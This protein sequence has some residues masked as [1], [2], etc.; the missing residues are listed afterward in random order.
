MASSAPLVVLSKPSFPYR[1]SFGVHALLFGIAATGILGTS[2]SARAQEDSDRPEAAKPVVVPPLVEHHHEAIYPPEELSARKH[3]EVVLVVTV[4]SEGHVTNVEVGQ[5]G[6]KPFDDAAIVAMRLWTFRPATRD[7]KPVASRFRVPFH[8]APPEIASPE[9]VPAPGIHGQVQIANEPAASAASTSNEPA[10]PK[11]PDE[12]PKEVRVIGRSS[13]PS[14]GGGDHDIAIGKLSAV[15]HM[16]AASLLRLAPGVLLTNE[17]GTG[18]PNQIFLR[19][20]DAREGQDIEFSVDGIP[21]NEV[22]NPHGNGTADTHFIIP[23]LV[24]RLRVVEGPFAPQQG[25]YAVAGSALYDVGLAEPGLSMKATMGSFATKRLLVMWRPEGAHEHTFGGAELFSSDGFGQNRASERATAMG[26]Y[27]GHLGE[28]GSYRILA[29]S[30]ATHYAQ[31]GVLRLDDV[32]AGRKDFY[33][34]YDTSQGGDSSRHSIGVTL[35]GKIGETKLS[36]SAFLIFRDFRLRQ[37]FT[38]FLNDPQQTW[39]SVHVQRGDLIDQRSQ[40]TTFGGRGSARESGNLFGQKQEFELGYLA[41][42]DRTDATQQRDRAGTTIPYLTDLALTSG[43]VNVGLYADASIKPLRW[44]TLRGGLRGDLY[45]YLVTNHCAQTSQSSFGGDPL[46][47]ECFSSDRLGY[48]SP[49]QTASTSASL[50][51]PRGT[52]LVGPFDGFTFSASYGRGSRSLDPQYV[53]QDL[54]TPFAQVDAEELGV[55]Y[56]KTIGNVDLD[57]RSVFFQTSVDKDLFFNQ[58]QGRNT[59]ANGTTRRG[60]A[61]NARATGNFFDVAASLTL[62][63]ATFDDTHQDIPY[64]PNVVARTDA[65]VFGDLPV[66]L[67]GKKLTGSIGPGISYVGP[68]PLPF[69]EKSDTIFLVDLGAQVRWRAFSLGFVATNLLDRKYRLSEFNYTSDFHSQPYPTLVA[70]RHFTAGEPRALYATLTVTLDGN[71]QGDKP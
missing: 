17:G 18:H 66:R 30:Y 36:Q 52:L 31:A 25:N 28:T 22:A 70:A 27:E 26:G 59:L 60:W 15:P 51:Q 65:V 49:D 21:I 13:M 41:R 23:E 35:N 32:Q 44:I 8:F 68:R 46:D 38:G 20:F 3:A 11:T 1:R 58:T 55:A 54:K 69:D 29:T 50:L 24:K 19:G 33:D 71:G 45:H 7:G 10:E 37:N 40:A 9:E 56:T 64:A 2:T 42:Y 43:V 4:D 61:G 67:L 53:N 47:T 12:G 5:S 57:A 62:V 39:Q 6:G 14:R 63:R 34:T 48:R 16:D